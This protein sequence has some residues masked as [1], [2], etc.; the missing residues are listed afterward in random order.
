MNVFIYMLTNDPFEIHEFLNSLSLVEESDLRTYN[1][2]LEYQAKPTPTTTT[3]ISDTNDSHSFL[4]SE[5]TEKFITEKSI[6]W[7]IKQ[8][9]STEKKDYRPKISLFIEIVA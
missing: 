9:E 1:D 3:T 6:N 2:S 8:R 5:L 7:G 4:L